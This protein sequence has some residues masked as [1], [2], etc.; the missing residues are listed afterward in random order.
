M[1]KD[2]DYMKKIT[3]KRRFKRISYLLATMIDVL[4]VVGIL[5]IF[6]LILPKNTVEA[7][8]IT[9]QEYIVMPGDTL[10]SIASEN[11]KE[12]QDVREY[13]YKLQL[14]NDVENC[15]IYPGQVIKII[16]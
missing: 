8:C 6:M 15:L 5:L 2:G 4:L 10:W 7:D 14:V 16:K 13:I 1:D 3:N 9:Y 12:G 11:K